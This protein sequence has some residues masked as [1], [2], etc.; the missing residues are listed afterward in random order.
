MGI[1]LKQ[2]FIN[3]IILFLGFGI[4][5]VNVLFLYTHF[6]H[7]DY[8]G[9]ITFLL[10]AANII[11]PILVYGMQHT[12]IKFYSSYKSKVEQDY[13]LTLTLVIPLIIIVPLSLIGTFIYETI[14]NLIS[15]ENPIIKQYTYLIFV[16]AIFMGYFE[17]FYSWTK[18]H[19]KSVFGNF[20]K[21]LFPRFCTS[22]LLIAVYL[23]W[24]TN[25][26]FIYAVVVVYG[27]STLIMMG[28]AF[29][30]YKPT[31]KFKLPE[32]I[33]E[34]LSFSTYIIVA[35]SAAGVLLEI[36]KFMIPQ[37]EQ[38]AQV[39]YYSVGIYIA[40]VIAIP[41]RAM[42]QITIPITAKDMN[43][44]NYAEVE[45]LYKQSSL[46]L[47]IV[48]G[49]FFLLINLNINDMYQLIN[50]PQFTKGIW[51]VL[52]I[53]ISKLMELALGTGNAI[54]VNSKYYKIFFY[55]SIAMAI[56]VILFNKWLISLM[57]IDGAALA[58]LIVVFM[59][60]LIKMAYIKMKLSMQPFSTNTIKVFGV[61][62]LL[63]IGFYFWNFSL[64]PLLNILLKSS[65]VLLFY[66][67]LISRFNISADLN[68][69]MGKYLKR[70]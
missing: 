51:V 27:V 70:K 52:I 18:V 50:K 15:A 29:Y 32:N 59:Y 5:G 8:F 43:E 17:V 25:Q 56:S 22:F 37:M 54:L 58:T 12:I 2:S 69:L 16:V 66:A 3:T 26:Q 4:G 67:F 65:V 36:D 53:S 42:Q 62:I 23:Q 64:H 44:N 14:A 19:M 7:E 41:T 31:F 11:L 60:S 68:L 13:F 47:L 38:I 46:N 9:L 30:V 49:L 6:L 48:G 57:G 28:Y 39:A 35:G 20:I 40:S 55:L 34:I 24:L 10:S 61:M 21:E 63:Y 1:V 45:K 33:K